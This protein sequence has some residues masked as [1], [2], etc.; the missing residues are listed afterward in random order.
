MIRVPKGVEPLFNELSSN[1]TRQATGKRVVWL[2]LAAV[3][4]TGN[5]TVSG[6]V[7][8]NCLVE[9]VNPSTY[10]RVLSHRRWITVSLAVAS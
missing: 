9:Y 2:M 4:V 10:H 7:R 8:L 6:V 1:F 5:R 3:L